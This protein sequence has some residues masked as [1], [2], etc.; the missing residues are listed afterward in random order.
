MPKKITSPSSRWP[1]FVVLVDP[2]TMPQALA[3]ERAVRTAQELNAQTQTEFEAALLPGI[4]A[5]VEKWELT[6][7][8]NVTPDTFPASPRAESAKLVGWLVTEITAI[9]AGSGEAQDPNG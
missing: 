8:E 6:G 5:C 3:W 9:Y 1:G 7:L 2:L 4:C